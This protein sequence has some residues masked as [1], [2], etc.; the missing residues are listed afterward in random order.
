MRTRRAATIARVERLLTGSH[1]SRRRRMNWPMLVFGDLLIFGGAIGAATFTRLGMPGW[2]VCA[3]V[4]CCCGV[5][6]VVL[7]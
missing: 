4:A 3:G 6:M 2:G 7:R 1:E 5:A